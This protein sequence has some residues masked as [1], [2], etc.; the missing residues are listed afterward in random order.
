M[1]QLPISYPPA[2]HI[3]RSLRYEVEHRPDFTSTASMEA[4]PNLRTT[5]GHVEIGA[6]ATLADATAG[7]LAALAAS[8]GWIATS[9]LTL[10]LAGAVNAER[11]FAH[12]RVLRRGNSKIVLAVDLES[13]AGAS[14]GIATMSFSVL[15]RR[16]GNPIMSS[17]S[18]VTTHSFLPSDGQLD[19]GS[20]EEHIH[21]A[22]GVR[23][24]TDVIGG[25]ESQMTE[26]VVNTL[27]AMQGGAVATLG[28]ASASSALQA[29]TKSNELFECVDLVITY[30]SLG[31]AGP[32]RA[33]AVVTQVNSDWGTARVEIR[34][35]GSENRLMAVVAAT[36]VRVQSLSNS[37]ET[38]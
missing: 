19:N 26:Y 34:D 3:L 36:A 6:L 38:L 16:D 35:A 11:V 13:E 15:P 24:I 32:I 23:T 27:G 7:G 29:T 21:E 2:K 20:V 17:S 4:G 25:V 12:G 14:L 33:S 8:P 28:A 5:S 10:H 30:L 18:E 9:D 31:K 1:T 37:H 22:I